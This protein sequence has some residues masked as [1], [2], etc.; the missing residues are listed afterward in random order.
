MLL[1]LERMK[2]RARFRTLGITMKADSS[3]RGRTD[4]LLELPWAF[5]ESVCQTRTVTNLYAALLELFTVYS[6]DESLRESLG[7]AVEGQG[8]WISGHS[9]DCQRIA[10]VGWDNVTSWR[11]AN[12]ADRQGGRARLHRGLYAAGEYFRLLDYRGTARSS[13]AD[14]KKLVIAAMGP[15]EESYQKQ[16]VADIRKRGAA[17]AALGAQEEN[18]WGADFYFPVRGIAD[19]AAWGLPFIA[20]CQMIAFYKAVERG[21]NPDMPDGLDPYISLD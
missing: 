15:W 10:S 19:Y 12:S 8:A 21:H 4:L 17:V 6:G 18:I 14:G 9:G 16:M 5:D 20:L 1:A 2:Q 11:T 7:R 3:L 13:W